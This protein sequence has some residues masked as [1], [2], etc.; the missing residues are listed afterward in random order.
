MEANEGMKALSKIFKADVLRRNLQ[1]DTFEMSVKGI[2]DDYLLCLIIPSD[3][4]QY[5]PQYAMELFGEVSKVKT[6][7][8]DYDYFLYNFLHRLNKRWDTFSRKN[9]IV[10]KGY[11]TYID[12]NSNGDFGVIIAKAE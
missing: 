6:E 5:V 10:A 7:A 4:G 12:Y 9:K 3:C 11:V 1:T 2:T 8:L